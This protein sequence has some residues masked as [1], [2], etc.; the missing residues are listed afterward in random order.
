[1]VR[2]WPDAVELGYQA[3]G[4]LTEIVHSVGKT[5]LFI[6]GPGRSREIC[7]SFADHPFIVSEST[8]RAVKKVIAAA[9][10][11]D[12]IVAIGGGKAID[13]GKMSAEL[14]GLPMVSVPTVL[15]GDGIASPIAVIDGVS[16]KVSV[17]SALV[18]D[19]EVISG[20]PRRH[21]AAGAGDLLS[22]I[23]S[24]WDWKRAHELGK[25]QDFNGLAAAM[26]ETG[27]LA[28][29][30]E[31]PDLRCADTLRALCQGLLLSGVAM[32]IAGSSK[33][34]S[35][36][37][38]KISHAMDKLLGGAGLHGEQVALAAVFTTYLQSNSH[39]EPMVSFMRKLGLPT[40]PD[41]LGLSFG[42]FARCVSEAPSTRPDRFTILEEAAPSGQPLLGLI[43]EAFGSRGL[44]GQGV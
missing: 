37:E 27:A 14:T 1:M 24:V 21:N 25:D 30:S 19:L 33:P 35:G 42:D 31:E 18:C 3:L 8:S 13:V 2:L 12:S 5:P 16:H 28:L 41:D 22:N 15:S 40:K 44:A 32:A 6:S 10:S 39:R 4:R 38:H 36:S 23:S 43:G 11:H 17:P 29:L 26:S 7:E 34:S 9:R 20:A